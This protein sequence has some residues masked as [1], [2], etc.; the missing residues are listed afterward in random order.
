[1]RTRPRA[2]WI[3]ATRV[4]ALAAGLTCAA[5]SDSE[6]SHRGVDGGGNGGGSSVPR[7]S[8]AGRRVNPRLTAIDLARFGTREV[9]Q[10]SDG[11][12]LYGEMVPLADADVCVVRRREAF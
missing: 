7:S 8:D 11:Q 2:G 4:S 1:M 3:L 9:E 12:P 5:C 10:G 6:S